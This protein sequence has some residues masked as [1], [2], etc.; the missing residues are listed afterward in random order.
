MKF[1]KR[2]FE[3]IEYARTWP[4]V[5]LSITESTLSS[6]KQS[7]FTEKP[8]SASSRDTTTSCSSGS[9]LSDRTPSRRNLHSSSMEQETRIAYLCQKKT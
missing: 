6:Y 8:R 5:R 9:T 7:L 3:A 4:M 1:G 2:F